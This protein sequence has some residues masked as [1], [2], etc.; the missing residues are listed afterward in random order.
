MR[1]IVVTIALI[2]AVMPAVAVDVNV[3]AGEGIVGKPTN[4]TIGITETGTVKTIPADVVLVM[5]CSG[6]MMRWG[7]IIT[8]PKSVTLAEKFEKIGEF[9]LDRP[10]DVEVMLQKPL[11]IYYGS[12][13]FEAYIVNKETG[14][15]SSIEKGYSI[16]RWNAI[17]PGTYEVYAKRCHNS[18]ANRIFCVELPPERLILAKSAAKRFVDMLGKD[19]R[20]ALVKFTSY[21]DDW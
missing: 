17:P 11:D 12:D 18:Y 1:L 8:K 5:D 13:K 19:D 2:L 14:W 16:V 6:S 7:N 4:F 3:N 9:K 10:S 20:V 15:R 21:Y